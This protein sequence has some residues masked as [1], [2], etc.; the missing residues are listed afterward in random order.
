MPKAQKKGGATPPKRSADS[1]KEAPAS[2]VVASKSPQMESSENLAKLTYKQ[3]S[4]QTMVRIDER[5]KAILD[6]LARKS[7]ESLPKLLHRAITDLKRKMF[8]DQID[9]TCRDI[10][11]NDPDTWAKYQAECDVFDRSASDGLTGLE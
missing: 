9:R 4:S 7:G 2:Y 3:K 6:E 5:D 11:E 10:K 1:V 8:F